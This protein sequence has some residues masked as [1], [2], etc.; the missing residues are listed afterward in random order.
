MHSIILDSVHKIFRPA[1][2]L[3]PRRNKTE[4]Y[5]IKGVSLSIS[6]G[7]VL[8]LLG[9]NGSGK[10]TTLKLISTVLLP[11]RGTILINGADTREHGRRVRQ[12]VGFA[13]AS[14]RSFF[15]RLTVRE[16]LDFFAALE[17]VPRSERAA[18]VSK[19][20]RD[21][22]LGHHSD[23]Q[24]M[25]LS[26]GLQQRLGIARALIKRPRVLLLDEPTR[27]LD[28]AAASQ[29]WILV[30]RLAHTGTTI[31]L[32]T[33]NFEEAVLAADRVAILQKGQ[34]LALRQTIG[35]TAEQLRTQ[36]LHATGEENLMPWPAE[37]PA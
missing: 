6:R 21:I 35:L 25:K 33:H 8:A 4:T 2:F 26:S 10:S 19:I 5:A 31:V 28:P 32:A 15:P 1:G 11:D 29:L 14:E 9:P 27:S 17:N 34:L 24:V 13:V 7:E 22:N 12:Q 36:Y 3:F 30:R 20:I 23:K 16:N 18:E 37:V